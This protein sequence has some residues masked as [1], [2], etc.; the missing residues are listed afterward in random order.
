MKTSSAKAKGRRLQKWVADRLGEALKDE[1]EAGDVQPAVMGQGGRDIKL[2]PAGE[3]ACPLDVECKNRERLN[4]WAALEQAEANAAAG[5]IPAVVFKRNRSETY[6]A[7]AFGDFLKL[8][9]G[10]P[11]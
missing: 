6:I 3:A 1:I 4:I 10:R 7:L 8:W 2:S 5:R 9:R 11:D